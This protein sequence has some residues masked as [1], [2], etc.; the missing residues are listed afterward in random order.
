[1]TGGSAAETGSSARDDNEDARADEKR[2][3]QERAGESERDVMR[4]FIGCHSRTVSSL[5]AIVA[6]LTRAG[7]AR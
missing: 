2:E 1:M 6:R 7:R 3:V 4:V 5:P